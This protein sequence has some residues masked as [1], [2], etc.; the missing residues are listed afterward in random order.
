MEDINVSRP[1]GTVASLAD[2]VTALRAELIKAMEAG[3]GEDP[4]FDVGTVT[5]EFA[6]TTTAD[7]EAKGGVRFWV[8]E[9]GASGS[10]GRSATHTITLEMQPRTRS[11]GKLSISDRE[12]RVS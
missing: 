9:L 2:T 3:K 6:V 5:M 11:G 12:L 10:I 4:R 7:T 8:I 1:M